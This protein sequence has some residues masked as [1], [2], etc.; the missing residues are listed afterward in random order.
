[1]RLIGKL[2]K[3]LAILV[4]A[5]VILAAGWLYFSPPA[6]IRVAAGY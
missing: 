6:L 1:M 2:L 3:W 5:A 4:A